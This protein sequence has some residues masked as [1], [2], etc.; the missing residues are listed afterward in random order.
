MIRFAAI[1]LLLMLAATTT[2]QDKK[3]LK[4]IEK[5]YNVYESGN[6]MAKSDKVAILGANLRFKI[7]SKQSETTSRKAA[8]QA[9][10]SDYAVLEGVDEAVLQELSNTYRPMLENRFTELGMEVL[11]YTA[12]EGSKSYD[13]LI[14]K[15]TEKREVVKKEWGVAKVY[16]AGEHPYLVIN[17]AAPFGP[18]YKIPK[19]LGALVVNS[20]MTIDFSHIGISISQGGRSYGGTVYTEGSSSVVPVIHIDGHTYNDNGLNMYKDNSYI[21]TYRDQ[22]KVFHSYAHDI[23]STKDYATSAE[24]CNDCTPAFATRSGFSLRAMEAGMGMV[25]IKADPEHFKAAVV[26]ALNQY[27]DEVFMLYKAQRS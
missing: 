12:I 3:E 2:A 25:V 4:A 24:R 22:N 21:F 17:G 19:E 20:T 5:K 9:R 15:S 1:A 23:E 13:K 18:Q 8:A 6:I 26:D 10:F 16:S 14:E 7:A 11:P 27:L